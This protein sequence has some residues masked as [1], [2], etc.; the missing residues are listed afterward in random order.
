VGW[1]S[2]RRCEVRDSR[3]SGRSLGEREEVTGWVR[4]VGSFDGACGE[5]EVRGMFVRFVGRDRQSSASRQVF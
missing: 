1:R 4:A 3:V 5:S 2:V